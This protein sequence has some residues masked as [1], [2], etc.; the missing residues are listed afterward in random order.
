MKLL[1]IYNYSL[2]LGVKRNIVMVCVTS[3]SKNYIANVTVNIDN[4]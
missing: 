3:R 4:L 1:D 2:S